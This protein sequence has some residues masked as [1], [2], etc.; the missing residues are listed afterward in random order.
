[1]EEDG[2]QTRAALLANFH[3]VA[4][5]SHLPIDALDHSVEGRLD[6]RADRGAKV[7]ALVAAP[8]AEER[9]DLVVV[10]DRRHREPGLEPRAVGAV[11][12]VVPRVIEAIDAKR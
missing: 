6:R 5:H 7:D 10:V 2:A 8:V 3:A 9:G 11:E 1:M 4:V 12:A